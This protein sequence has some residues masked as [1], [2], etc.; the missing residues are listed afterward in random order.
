MLATA[1]TGRDEELLHDAEVV[2]QAQQTY[3]ADDPTRGLLRDEESAAALQVVRLD[4][5]EV[6]LIADRQPEVELVVLDT[7]HQVDDGGGITALEGTDIHGCRLS[8]D[9]D[10]V[11]MGGEDTK[12][13]MAGSASPTRGVR[14][15]KAGYRPSSGLS[16]RGPT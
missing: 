7:E 8:M 10:G 16:L 14:R 5:L 13:S 6:A 3:A 1:M 15:S 4:V 12:G 2:A 9:V 11:W